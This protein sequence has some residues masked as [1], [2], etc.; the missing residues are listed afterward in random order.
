[1]V[2]VLVLITFNIMR[3]VHIVSLG[4]V[5]RIY[6]VS[7]VGRAGLTMLQMFQLKRAYS[8]TINFRGLP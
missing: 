5:R 4:F 7:V 6:K 8:E 2:F 3:L 1:M